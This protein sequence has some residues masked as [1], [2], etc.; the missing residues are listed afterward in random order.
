MSPVCCRSAGRSAGSW[1]CRGGASDLSHDSG[2]VLL[3]NGTD[4]GGAVKEMRQC[5]GVGSAMRV[6]LVGNGSLSE[7]DRRDI[8]HG[9]FDHV[10]R[11]NDMKNW[12][13]GERKTLHVV[14]YRPDAW[15]GPFSGLSKYE[16]GCPLVLVGDDDVV[17]TDMAFDKSEVGVDWAATGSA[18]VRWFVDVLVVEKVAGGAMVAPAIVEFVAAELEKTAK[19]D[20]QARKA[21]EEKALMRAGAP[22][23]TSGGQDPGGQRQGPKGRKQQ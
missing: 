11:F 19:V 4:D 2:I 21:R 22:G 17:L 9:G 1:R 15:D 12:R 7:H 8:E 5:L 18:T 20:K 6:A 3:E 23:D 10:L 14:R 16:H 13:K